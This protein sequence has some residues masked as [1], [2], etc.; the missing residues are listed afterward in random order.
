M[1]NAP[2]ELNMSMAQTML[3]QDEFH[4]ILV[5]EGM[6]P[7]QISR[8]GFTPAADLEQ[9][10]ALVSREHRDPS[11]NVVPA[12]GVILPIIEQQ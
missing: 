8:L 1:A 5:A 7:R 3:A 4:I 2:P 11:V 10:I 12:G 6:T 9:A